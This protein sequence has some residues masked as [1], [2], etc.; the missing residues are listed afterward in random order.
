MAKYW[1]KPLDIDKIKTPR[2]KIYIL[3]DR[4]KG[5]AFCVEFC[6]K[7]VL[8]ISKEYNA[9]GYYPPF[10]KNPDDCIACDQCSLICPDF[11]IY[12]EEEKE[13]KP[14]KHKKKKS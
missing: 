7:K 2:G 3:K 11:A 14:V 6:P 4:C 10:V 5:C 8:E 9:K 13:K 1:R 12:C